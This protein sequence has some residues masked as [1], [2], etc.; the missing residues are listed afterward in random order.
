MISTR[1]E[2]CLAL[3][4]GI[5]STA[6]DIKA[7]YKKLVKIYHPDAGIS[8]DADKYRKIVEAY[9]YLC[10]NPVEIQTVSATG[11][12]LGNTDN[13]YYKRASYYSDFEKK[14]QQKKEQNAIDFEKK[15]QAYEDT[16]K[17]EKEEFDRAMEVINNI[18]LAEAIRQM[19]RNQ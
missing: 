11:R 17:R 7:A 1:S 8:S 3:G 2:A 14:Y 19:I 6:G 13:S 10:N 9:E 5:N 16:R 12:V 4:I 15:M 18:R